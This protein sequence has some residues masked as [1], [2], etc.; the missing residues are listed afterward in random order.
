[1]VKFV[2]IHIISLQVAEPMDAVQGGLTSLE[3]DGIRS[4]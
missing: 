2:S 3:V 1:M 4:G